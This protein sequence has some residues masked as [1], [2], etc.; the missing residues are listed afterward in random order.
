[1]TNILPSG[2][3][4]DQIAIFTSAAKRGEQSGHDKLAEAGL[5]LHQGKAVPLDFTPPPEAP[6]PEQKAP[7]EQPRRI[8]LGPSYS[9]ADPS[10][11]IGGRA[12]KRR[13][14]PWVDTIDSL[15]PD[16][17]YSNTEFPFNRR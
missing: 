11:T 16:K 13:S 12:D 8:T 6:A 7:A 4:E 10:R 14:S 3:T 2:Y 5:K 9:T 17:G 1:M 15:G